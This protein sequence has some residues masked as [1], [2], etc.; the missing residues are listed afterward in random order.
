MK[1]KITLLLMALFLGAGC[2]WADDVTISSEAEWKS[3]VTT[4][5]SSPSTNA[6]LTANITLTANASNFANDYMPGTSSSPYSGTFD[7][8]GFT[9][10]YNKN[11][12]SEEVQGLFRYI[13]GATIKNLRTEGSLESSGTV[14]GGIVGQALGTCTITNCA[15]SVTLTRTG[16]PTDDATYGGIVGRTGD[17]ST[18]NISIQNCIYTG[19]ISGNKSISGIV[20]YV[21]NNCTVNISNTLFAGTLTS[22]GSNKCNFYRSGGTCNLVSNCYYISNYDSQ[23]T[24]ATSA[25]LL[26]GELAYTLASADDTNNTLFWGQGNLNKSN[27]DAYPNL[28][29]EATKKVVKVDINGMS[30]KPCVNPGGAI[31][32]PC[33]FGKLGFKLNSG[34]AYSLE[35]MPTEGGTFTYGTSKLETTTGMYCITLSAAATTLILPFDCESLPD[36]ITAYD[37]TY[38]SGDAVTA[39]QVTKITADKPVL[40]NGTAGTTY[41]FTG[42]FGGTFSGTLSDGVKAHTNGALTGVYVDANANSGYNPIAYVPANSY[43]LQNGTEGLGFYQVQNENTVR[44][45]SFRAYLTVQSGS[46]AARRLTI[47][48]DDNNTTGIKNIS[49]QTNNDD[50]IYTLNG[51]RVDHPVKGLYIKNGKKY[52]V[53]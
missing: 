5:K 20:G 15:S 23:G 17:N 50:A 48:F 44:I 16:S 8:Q 27:I 32:N 11:G 30:T 18:G 37:V 39:T 40:I 12:L 29:S 3:F 34:D 38:S 25:N 10:T 43:V 13:S 9:V 1:N 36:G 45:T 47:T 41:K 4:V 31:P 24:A 52:I 28:T 46:S 7:G 51:T 21:R 26:N 49:E 53:K 19:V 2:V 33:R 6:K 42:T 22:T 35:T 14:M